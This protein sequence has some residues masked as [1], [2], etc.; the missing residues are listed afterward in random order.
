[1]FNSPQLPPHSSLQKS[2]F[3]CFFVNLQK[4]IWFWLSGAR[5]GDKKD[6]MRI[7][8]LDIW[9]VLLNASWWNCEI[10]T[11]YTTTAV[12]NWIKPEFSPHFMFVDLCVR[13]GRGDKKTPCWRANVTSLKNTHH[14]GENVNP[15]EAIASV[16]GDRSGPWTGWI[17]PASV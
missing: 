7:I 3:V 17:G 8:G 6:R 5:S 16:A 4:I 9:V 12:V 2:G 15:F 10:L 14:N 11:T 13:T 1:M